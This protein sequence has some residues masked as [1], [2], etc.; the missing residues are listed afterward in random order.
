MHNAVWL[1]YYMSIMKYMLCK[2]G[3]NIVIL[4]DNRCSLNVVGN[5]TG[6]CAIYLYPQSGH[7][8]WQT[9]LCSNLVVYCVVDYLCCESSL[10]YCLLCLIVLKLIYRRL[11]D[12]TGLIANSGEYSIFTTGFFCWNLFLGLDFVHRIIY[13][14]WYSFIVRNVQSLSSHAICRTTPWQL[15]K[16][17]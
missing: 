2:C 4:K 10:W 11:H 9:P 13:V 6:L 14:T 12:M 8:S 5:C 3:D 16:T 7:F 15:T 17:V 1:P